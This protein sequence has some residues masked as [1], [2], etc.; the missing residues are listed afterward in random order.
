MLRSCIF[1]LALAATAPLAAAQPPNPQIDYPAYVRLAQEVRDYR[2]ARLIDWRTFLAASSD[3]DVLILDARSERQFAQGHLAGAINV[4][5][6]E[7]SAER[8]AEVIGRHDRPILIYC[9]NNFRNDRPPV[10]LKSGP[11]ALNIPTFLHLVAYG[12]RNIR[13]LND[14]LDID[15]P[16][17]PWVAG[18][19]PAAVGG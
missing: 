17:L 16:R 8:L 19:G 4:P 3:P 10:I 5:L 12:Y 6:P 2:A 11:V 1:L 14:V 13:E 15:D 9:N 18:P 7:F